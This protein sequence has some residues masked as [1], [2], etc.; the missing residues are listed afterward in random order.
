LVARCILWVNLNPSQN[1]E[2]FVVCLVYW[3]RC[4]LF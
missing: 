3:V 2:G 1:N 4:L